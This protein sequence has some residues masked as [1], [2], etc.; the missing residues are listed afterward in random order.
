MLFYR[1]GFV[2][3]VVFKAIEQPILD[4][5]FEAEKVAVEGIAGLLRGDLL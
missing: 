2:N 4:A 3:Y 5:D 1:L